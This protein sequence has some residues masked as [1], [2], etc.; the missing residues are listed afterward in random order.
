MVTHRVMLL[1]TLALAACSTAPSLAGRPPL[2]CTL[3]LLKNGP[4]LAD[5]GKDD[6]QKVM[7]GHLGNIQRLVR[8]RQ[9]LVAGPYGRRK[10]DAALRGVFVFDTA[11][12]ARAQALAETDPGFQAGVF[13]FEYHALRTDAPLRE[14]LAAYLAA[15]EAAAKAGTPRAMGDG[16]RGYVLL[17]AENGD[18]AAAVFAG[19][20]SAPWFARMDDSRALVLLDAVDL[21]AAQAIVAPFAARLG[22]VRM[23]EWFASAALAEM[24]KLPR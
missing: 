5:T 24:A 6:L 10:S 3:V 23:D 2:D 14:F 1:V 15:D 19:N 8:E 21:D 16:M 17:I 12:R 4:H 18:A 20:K 22:A 13:A 7:G 9:L 11:D